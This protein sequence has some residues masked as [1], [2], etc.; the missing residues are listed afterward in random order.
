MGLESLCGVLG[1]HTGSECILRP[2]SSGGRAALL[3]EDDGMFQQ[4]AQRGGDLLGVVR[5]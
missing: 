4:L 5:N 3:Q 1:Y 2:P